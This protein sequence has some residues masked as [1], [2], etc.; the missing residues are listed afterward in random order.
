MQWRSACARFSLENGPA[1][2]LPASRFFARIA[3]TT[4]RSRSA[5]CG[6]TL[7]SFRSPAELTPPEREAQ[8]AL[9]APHLDSRRWPRA[10]AA[11]G[12]HGGKRGRGLLAMDSHRCDAAVSGGR[13]HGAQSGL[14]ALFLGHHRRQ[15][16]R[17]FG[18]RHAARPH[19]LRP[20]QTPAHAARPRLVDAADGASFRGLDRPLPRRRN[21]DGPRARAPRRA[22]A[23]HGAGIRRHRFLWL[24]FSP[25]TARRGGVADS[26]GRA[27]G[28]LFPRRRL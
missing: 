11:A 3:L 5:F 9:T 28:S 25:R 1:F 14:C 12:R 10:V 4:W 13:F 6:R 23:G 16:G 22:V 27:C 17:R 15:Q 2:P 8:V 21:D 19:R 26:R 20:A 18:T 24:A 7:V